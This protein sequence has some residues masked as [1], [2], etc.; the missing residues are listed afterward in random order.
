MNGIDSERL[1]FWTSV[2]ILAIGIVL[3]YL[4]GIADKGGI[5]W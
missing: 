1:T 3:G 2:L 5:P 4:A